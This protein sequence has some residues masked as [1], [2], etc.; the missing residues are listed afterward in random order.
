MCRQQ[1][2]VKGWVVP[3][4]ATISARRESEGEGH[5]NGL[6]R[7]GYLIQDGQAAYTLKAELWTRPSEIED[8]SP[9]R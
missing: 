3:A 8:A 5:F 1:H 2:Q 6:V 7:A 4:P 9:D